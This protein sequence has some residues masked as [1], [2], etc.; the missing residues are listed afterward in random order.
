[1]VEKDGE[2]RNPPQHPGGS[3]K[4]AFDLWKSAD[5]VLPCAQAGEEERSPPSS[6]PR[7]GHSCLSNRKK[8][9]GRRNSG[10][11]GQSFTRESSSCVSDLKT[12]CVH[13]CA[14]REGEG[15]QGPSHPPPWQLVFRVPHPPHTQ[16]EAWGCPLPF[17][18][19]Q[20]LGGKVHSLD[21]DRSRCTASPPGSQNLM[22]T[23][24]PRTQRTTQAQSLPPLP[25]ASC[26]SGLPAGPLPPPPPSSL[27]SSSSS[28]QFPTSPSPALCLEGL[29]KGIHS[30]PPMCG[31]CGIETG[32]HVQKSVGDGVWEA[33][34]EP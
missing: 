8:V 17:L 18:S 13:V 21:H 19:C 4:L 26:I 22:N 2:G 25:A 16:P 33:A 29:S 34:W 7:R 27:P 1:M 10:A 5:G 23:V 24:D 3:R 14:G 31:F 12:H 6:C 32:Q 20:G 11:W 15:W 30:A 9:F 28:S